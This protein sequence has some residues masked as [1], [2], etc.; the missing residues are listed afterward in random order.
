MMRIGKQIEF[1][2]VALKELKNGH[3]NGAGFYSSSVSINTCSEFT[4]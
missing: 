2:V 1:Y 4:E 3:K